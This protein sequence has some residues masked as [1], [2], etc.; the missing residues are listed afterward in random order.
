MGER[1]HK[2]CK[3]IYQIRH[4]NNLKE[5]IKNTEERYGE[6]D[7]FRFKTEKEQEFNKISYKEYIEE[8]NALGTALIDIGLKDKRIGV[9][10]ENRYEWEEA[11]LSIV[12]GVGIVVPLDKSLP[13][14]EI[15][16]LIER[17]EIE[18]IFYSSKYD[19]IMKEVKEKH[20]GKIKYF[21]SMEKETEKEIYS[22]KD[23]VEKG[24]K[25]L[26]SGDKRYLK[27]EIDNEKMSI[28]LFTSGTTSKSKA[29]ALSH[30]NICSN[31]YDIL[32]VYYIDENDT[33]LSFL[34]LHHTFESTVGFLCPVCKGSCIVF[35]EGIRHIADNIKE[36]QVSVMISV[37]ILFEN[38]YRRILKTL[39]KKGKLKTFEKGKRI[40]KFLLKF[41]IDKRRK[42]FKEVLDSFGGRLRLFVAGAAAF[43]S[44][45][46]EGYN[47]IGI[48]TYQGYG[49]TEASPVVAAE[50]VGAIRKGSVGKIFS[51]L[52]GKII[53]PNEQG[54]GEIAVKGPTTMIGYYENEQAT[55]ETFENEWLLT[56][57]LGYF[58][59]DDYLFITGR[60]KNV[61]VLKNGKNIYPE[62]LEA[63]LEKIPGVKESLVFGKEDHDDDLKI[64]AKIVVDKDGVKNIYGTDVIEDLKP[65]IW[66]KVKEINKKMP[67]YKYIRE[68]IVTDEELI[69]TTTQKVKRY[70]EMKKI[71]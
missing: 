29:V 42:L 17:S 34:P 15:I 45:V 16:S 69:K 43:D 48:D 30:K 33:F 5:M 61:I 36:Y 51:S 23:L 57:D 25:L 3:R 49:L 14:N 11:Y 58:D 6:K 59:R 46:A 20:I 9:I 62:E 28:M 41:G 67:A 68:I 19:N 38:M 39:E 21:I 32:S 13:G 18:A 24:K 37:P 52:E 1:I 8:I 10:S 65:E 26:E 22:Q 53:N 7:A 71:K 56:G 2:G 4:F 70:E 12:C 60:K 63:L 35:C 44:E 64:C 47:A 31:I 66:Q 55:E 54:I 40:S 27:A 50:H